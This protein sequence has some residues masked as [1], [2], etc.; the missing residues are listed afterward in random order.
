MSDV[1]RGLALFTLI[2]ML[3]FYGSK[4]LQGIRIQMQNK[5]SIMQ[6]G[7]ENIDKIHLEQK[8]HHPSFGADS[9][10]TGIINVQEGQYRVFVKNDSIFA[11]KLN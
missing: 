8:V 11:I 7:Y 10:T 4:T 6:A 5:D 2:F 1:L 3:L 9:F